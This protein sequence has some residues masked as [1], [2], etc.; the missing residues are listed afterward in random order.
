VVFDV[1]AELD[2]YS[3]SNL[4][5][6]NGSTIKTAYTSTLLNLPLSTSVRTKDAEAWIYTWPEGVIRYGL[7]ISNV[8]NS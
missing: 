2:A 6:Y 7:W 4:D 3:V 8:V 1:V 5:G